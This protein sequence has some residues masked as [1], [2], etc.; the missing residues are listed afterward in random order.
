MSRKTNDNCSGVENS[1]IGRG[2]GPNSYMHVLFSKEFNTAEH[3]NG[4]PMIN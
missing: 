3:E 4:P 1:L 2:G